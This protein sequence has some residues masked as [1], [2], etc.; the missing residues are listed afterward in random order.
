MSATE[1]ASVSKPVRKSGF[2]FDKLLFFKES[3]SGGTCAINIEEIKTV[4]KLSIVLLI[5]SKLYR[6]D[7]KVYKSFWFVI[8]VNSVA[9][10]IIAVFKVL[11]PI[12]T[13]LSLK[14]YGIIR[15]GIEVERI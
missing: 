3:V 8:I 2:I 7:F 12:H 9:T 13:S 1:L 15:R 5:F 14:S 11:S 6:F 4:I 10:I